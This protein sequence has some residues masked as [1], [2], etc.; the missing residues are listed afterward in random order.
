MCVCV[1]VCVCQQINGPW[2][3]SI[4]K[5]RVLIIAERRGGKGREINEGK[6]EGEDGRARTIE[7]DEEGEREQYTLMSSHT[8]THTLSSY[9]YE[10][11]HLCLW[12][13]L[14]A[15]VSAAE[16]WCGSESSE[17]PTLYRILLDFTESVKKIKK[18]GKKS[19]KSSQHEFQPGAHLLSPHVKR[20]MWEK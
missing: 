10:D 13:S 3:G 2:G 20:Y 16:V 9:K 17:L 19:L 1:C 5:T 15:L 8:H 4:R 7:T 12:W 6:W 18:N 11:M 14:F